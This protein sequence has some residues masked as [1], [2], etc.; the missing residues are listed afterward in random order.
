MRVLVIVGNPKPESFDLA[1]GA[2]YCDGA[3]DAGH[4]AELLDLAALSF[5][6]IL[7]SGFAHQPLE[8]D[9]E[10]AQKSI[11]AADHVVWI[12]PL[13]YMLPPALLKGFIERAFVADFAIKIGRPYWGGIPNYTPLLKG[14]SARQVITMQM[15]GLL[16]RLLG[17]SLAARAMEHG[18]LRFVGFAPV[19]RTILGQVVSASDEKRKRWLDKM[20]D[21]GRNGS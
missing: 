13:Y 3:R 6:P 9:L 1:L 8:P 11:A 18:V 7:R 20:R 4:E 5:D 12:W 2:A 15:P 21:L 16:Y 19:R 10:A 14:K 17:S